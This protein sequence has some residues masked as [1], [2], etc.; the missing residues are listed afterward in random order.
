MEVSQADVVQPS[1]GSRFVEFDESKVL[2]IMM[3][4]YMTGEAQDINTHMRGA[5][6]RL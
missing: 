3:K 6:S 4:D 1:Q 5:A 2:A